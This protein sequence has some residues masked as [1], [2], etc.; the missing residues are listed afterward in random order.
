M[1]IA[2]D[3]DG[4]SGRGAAVVEN[5]KRRQKR[6]VEVHAGGTFGGDALEGGGH[7]TH[8]FKAAEIFCGERAEFVL[9]VGG[10]AIEAALAEQ[11]EG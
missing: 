9:L 1:A 4:A 7:Q 6:L 11:G 10:G 3:G 5:L 8:R 2:V